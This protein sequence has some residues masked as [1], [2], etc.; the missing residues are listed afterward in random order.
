MDAIALKFSSLE[1]DETWNEYSSYKTNKIATSRK[2]RVSS[3]AAMR[4]LTQQSKMSDI[5][6]E[7]TVTEMST[8]Q[9]GIKA[10]MEQVELQI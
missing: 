5:T 10:E 4:R 2:T 9:D 8:R 1:A 3:A 6:E 7:D